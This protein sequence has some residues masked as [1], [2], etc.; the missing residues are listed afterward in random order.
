M[1]YSS[2]FRVDFLEA[3]PLNPALPIGDNRWGDGHIQLLPVFTNAGGTRGSGNNTSN[4]ADEMEVVLTGLIASDEITR[5]ELRRNVLSDQIVDLLD[6]S[7]GQ[8]E[9][10]RMIFVGGFV[11]IE[12]MTVLNDF[13]LVEFLEFPGFLDVLKDGFKGVLT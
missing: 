12:K 8:P 9:E 13:F 3:G 5:L 11:D 10:F 7:T 2:S 4:P 1:E 6:V